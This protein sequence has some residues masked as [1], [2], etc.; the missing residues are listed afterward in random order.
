VNEGPGVVHPEEC[1][2][3]FSSCFLRAHDEGAEGEQQKHGSANLNA[4]RKRKLATNLDAE[5]KRKL[6]T[7]LDAEK[8]RK[9]AT[10]RKMQHA[11]QEKYSI[12]LVCIVFN[13]TSITKCCGSGSGI[14]CLFDPWI[15]DP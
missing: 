14:R 9:L 2:V 5:K 4:E 11:H 6:A 13:N 1:H 7:N 10:P 15:R 12:V 3:A 8:K